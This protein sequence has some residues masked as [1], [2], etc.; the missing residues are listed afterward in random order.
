MPT[1]KHS[2]ATTS[3]TNLHQR[4][5]TFQFEKYPVSIYPSQEPIISIN[6]QAVISRQNSLIKARAVVWKR[7]IDHCERFI[8]PSRFS[9]NSTTTNY[10]FFADHQIKTEK[11]STV[12]Q[13]S[14]V[15]FDNSSPTTFFLEIF[16]LLFTCEQL[17][18]TSV[19]CR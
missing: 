16:N 13:G 7:P 1:W 9:R 12:L 8:S 19:I 6:A 11:S 3:A 17:H 5:I 14:V 15:I 18:Q 4:L 2:E 10:L